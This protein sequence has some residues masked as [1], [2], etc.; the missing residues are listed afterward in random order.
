MRIW[1]SPLL[2]LSLSCSM[3]QGP[4]GLPINGRV[5]QGDA[6]LEGC[7]V[8]TFKGNEVVGR[9]ITER[10]GR[11]GVVLG[12]GEEFAIEFRKEGFLPKRVIV[13]TR[14]ELPKDL[15]DIAPIEMAMSMLKAEKY[16]GADT[17]EL[18]FPF[19][20]VRYDR[21]AKAF[22]QDY[23]YTADMMRTNGALLLMSGRAGKD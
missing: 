18:D 8:I 10:S 21:G 12:L 1:L 11:F 2:A 23:Q 4:L 17:D 9:Q 20:I 14:G 16:E 7:E 3:A 6:K 19:A 5:S 13:D 22:V 15:V